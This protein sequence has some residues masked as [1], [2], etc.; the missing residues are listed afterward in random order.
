MMVRSQLQRRRVRRNISD[1]FEQ[2]AR[3]RLR[4][5]MV[6]KH[7]MKLTLFAYIRG[8]YVTWFCYAEEEN[9]LDFESDVL[10]GVIG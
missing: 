5:L 6:K 3:T 8:V 1:I 7:V 2:S 10:R 9:K 4:E